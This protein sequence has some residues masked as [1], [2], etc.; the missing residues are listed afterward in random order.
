MDLFYRPATFAKL[1]PKVVKAYAL[2]ALEAA[3]ADDELSGD[4]WTPRLSSLVPT[5]RPRKDHAP[6]AGPV[7]WRNQLTR[8]GVSYKDAGFG[9]PQLHSVP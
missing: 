3:E 1:L 8:S 4:L 2:D 9:K 6:S 5:F 7:G